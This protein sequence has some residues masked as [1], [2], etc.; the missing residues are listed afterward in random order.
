MEQIYTHPFVIVEKIGGTHDNPPVFDVA[1][2]DCDGSTFVVE[3]TGDRDDAITVAEIIAES[4]DSW[5]LTTKPV[6]EPEPP[7][8]EPTVA[9]L[10]REALLASAEVLWSSVNEWCPYDEVADHVND[11]LRGFLPDE[12]A[13]I[14]MEWADVNGCSLKMALDHYYVD[15]STNP[16]RLTAWQ[17]VLQSQAIHPGWSPEE[18]RRF[19]NEEGYEVPLIKGRTPDEVVARWLDENNAWPGGPVVRAGIDMPGW[20][21]P[22]THPDSPPDQ[23]SE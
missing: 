17:V 23:G 18:H 9:P 19:L 20:V 16:P 11:L 6:P 13:E 22:H 4:F 3:A 2:V 10:L 5:K 12:I 8:P 7:E 14:V 21:H 15:V 1:V